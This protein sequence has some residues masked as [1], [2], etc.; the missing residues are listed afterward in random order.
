LARKYLPPSIQYP[1]VQAGGKKHAILLEA[2]KKKK[3]AQSEDTE[4]AECHARSRKAGELAR[5]RDIW[6]RVPTIAPGLSSRLCPHRLPMLARRS[7]PHCTCARGPRRKTHGLAAEA[8]AA[9]AVL[10]AVE[11][12]RR[13]IINRNVVFIRARP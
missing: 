13:P 4:N 12:L 6:D 7:P 8:T 2:A 11:R 3:P 10:H 1:R 9:L 5:S